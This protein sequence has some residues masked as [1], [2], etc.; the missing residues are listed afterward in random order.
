MK[1]EA[2]AGRFFWNGHHGPSSPTQVDP[3]RS[4]RIPLT[5]G[6]GGRCVYWAGAN[7]CDHLCY[8]VGALP[9]NFSSFLYVFSSHDCARLALNS[10]PWSRSLSAMSWSLLE[11]LSGTMRC[12]AAQTR[13]AKAIITKPYQHLPARNVHHGGR[14]WHW[15]VLEYVVWSSVGLHQFDCSHPVG[16]AQNGHDG[17][18]RGPSE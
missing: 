10:S 8:H 9:V 4:F 2:Q 13:A 11:Q 15:G 16:S 7:L 14:S 6:K 18:S 5:Q 17:L 12:V 1:Y 3:F